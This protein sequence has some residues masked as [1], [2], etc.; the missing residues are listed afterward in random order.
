MNSKPKILY[1]GSQRHI[2]SGVIRPMPAHRNNMKTKVTAVFATSNFARAKNYACMRVI[3]YGLKSPIENDTLYVHTLNPD[4]SG[5]KAYVYEL[6]SD[7]FELDVGNSYYSLIDKPIK[8]ETIIDVMQEI[9]EGRIKVYV[10][11]PE[12][13]CP[14]DRADIWEELVKDKDNFELYKPN[15]NS[16]NMSVLAQSMKGG[17]F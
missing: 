6:D 15:T 14:P 17:R 16:V 1:H 7:G 11:K 12:I 3:A 5:K 4:I 13:N 2:E 9:Q 8:K 10:L